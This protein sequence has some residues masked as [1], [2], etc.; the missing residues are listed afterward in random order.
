MKTKTFSQKPDQDSAGISRRKFLGS[1]AALIGGSLISP[2]SA[3]ASAY[4]AGSDTLK[5]ALIGAGAR[6]T[7]AVR[8]AIQTEGP[9]ELVA[10]ADVF[11]D[12]ID[13]SY[14]NLMNLQGIRD[15]IKVP[16]EHKFVGLDS[17]KQAIDLADVV[18]LASPPAFRPFHFEYAVQAGKHVFME[19]PLA[20]DAPGV[21]KVLAAGEEADRKGLKVVVGL[22]NRYGI[23]QNELVKRLHDGMIGE[24]TSAR[25]QYYINEINLVPRKEGQSELEYQL[26]NW[27][28]FCW[29]WAGSPAALTIHV[30][31]IINWVKDDYPIR[32]F[33]TGGRAVLKEPDHGDIYDHFYIEYEYA[34]GMRLHSTTRHIPGA[35]ANRGCY[36]EGT[37][38]RANHAAW[39]DTD[40]KN[41]E[42]DV[43][44]SYQDTNDPS[45]FQIE[46]DILYKAIREDIPHNDTEW[47]AKSTMTDIMGRM[48]VHSGGL[49]EW[50][51]ALSSD[52][53]LVPEGL[54]LD[55]EAPVQPLADGT[56][57]YPVP[58]SK[59]G[60][61]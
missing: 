59:S 37:R 5:V 57:P 12:K 60:I 11:R 2:L 33:G 30:T 41:M 27:R 45:P 24:I 39:R 20:S 6:G 8:D 55:S 16:E 47:G 7:G 31:D 34:D 49:I 26:S 14:N 32:A 28:H 15:H 18:I 3:R 4:V 9:V 50:D 44:W 48:A 21:R 61:V 54:T 58:G 36:F 43:I 53:V 13:T 17:Y 51:E 40:I 10:M 1:S 23:R 35:W 19:K 52:V 38:G 46:N 56:Y 25:C 29:L 42:G 22:Q